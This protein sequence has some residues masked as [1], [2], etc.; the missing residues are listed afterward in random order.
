L[1][2]TWWRRH[3]NSPATA[4]DSVP[5]TVSPTGEDEERRREG[6]AYLSRNKVEREKQEGTERKRVLHP[7]YTPSNRFGSPGPDLGLNRT[8]TQPISNPVS[9]AHVFPA[10]FIIL[11]TLSCI[12]CLIYITFYLFPYISSLLS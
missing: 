2:P 7:L 12:A 5:T 4:S 9:P 3:D 11:I 1:T 8:G 10:C 6:R